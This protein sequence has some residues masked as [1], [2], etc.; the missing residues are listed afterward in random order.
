M[1]VNAKK[2][3]HSWSFKLGKRYLTK[4][5]VHLLGQNEK[6]YKLSQADRQAIRKLTYKTYLYSA[7]I[8]IG[9]VLV[10]VLPFH[11]TSFFD[12]QQF[13]LFGYK[14]EFELYYS[15]YAIGM[16]FPEIWLLNLTHIRAVKAMCEIAHYPG[17]DRDDYEE[18]IILLTEAGFDMPGK[19]MERFQI[20]PYLGLS[21]FSY[22]GLFVL[23]KLKATLTNVVVKLMV[24]RLLG[25]YALRIVTD[26]MGLP[27]FAF[28]N[29]YASKKV[30]L[31]AR[32][33]I[34]ASSATRAFMTSFQEEEWTRM[35]PYLG[36]LFHFVA[37]QK[38]AYNFALYAFMHQITQRVGAV[39][40]SCDREL[41]W[42][43]VFVADDETNELLSR[44]FVF[45]LIIDGSLSVRERLTI[46]K[47]EKQS[48][49]LFET[50]DI[51][52][53]LKHYKEGKGV[54]LGELS[55]SQ[56]NY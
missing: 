18:Q 33:R 46:N 41:N 52:R 24:R 10:V 20:N 49:F 9:A 11:F 25:R 21:T 27:I 50:A 40:L 17:N 12:A 45:A 36:K 38:R 42:E 54:V 28:W 26:L 19:H 43:D 1:I 37:Q 53:T 5:T 34:M 30:L 14:F 4:K 3:K 7:L 23:N 13:E 6:G 8:G 35:T 48:W 29:A 2:V 55:N 51:E 16:L 56:L 15:L 32:T 47:L 31:E 22:Y 39:D 44:L